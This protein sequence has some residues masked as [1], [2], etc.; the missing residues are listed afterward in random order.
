MIGRGQRKR[1]CV[2]AGTSGGFAKFVRGCVTG[3]GLVACS[4]LRRAG[5]CRPLRVKLVC[6]VVQW[7][8]RRACTVMRGWTVYLVHM[9]NG[10]VHSR[11]AFPT[12]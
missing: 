1:M 11:K 7:G 3:R 9:T 2:S 6:G 10:R 12:A 8:C 5:G 4:T